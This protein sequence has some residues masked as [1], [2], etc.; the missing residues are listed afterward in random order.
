[1]RGSGVSAAHRCGGTRRGATRGWCSSE[2]PQNTR[3]VC[4][5]EAGGRDGEGFWPDGPPYLS[6]TL[7]V[8]GFLELSRA[9]SSLVQ[10]S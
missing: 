7:Q 2:T 10:V 6:L 4:G 8:L 3:W 9:V 5:S 1:M